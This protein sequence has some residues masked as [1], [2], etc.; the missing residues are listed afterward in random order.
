LKRAIFNVLF[1]ALFVLTSLSL[2]AKDNLAILPFTGGQGDEGETIAELFSFN[3][4]LKDVFIPIPRT[5]ITQAVEREQLFQMDSGMTNFKTIV[6]IAQQLGAR[7]V[8]AGHITSI[9]NNKLLVISIIDI[10]NLQQVTGD[11]QT[12]TNMLDIR[13]KLP[14]MAANIIQA[15]QRN[16]ASLPKLAVVP[17]QLQGGV[18]QRVAD[19]LTQILSIHLIRS[20]KY[21][22]YPRTSSLEQVKEEYNMQ[23]AFAAERN[24]ISQGLGENPNL[25]LSVVARKLENVNMFN[26]VIIDLFTG[27]Q[28]IGRSVDYRDIDEGIRAMEK[29]TIELTSTAEEI[30]QQDAKAQKKAKWDEIVANATRNYMEVLSGYVQFGEDILGGG[31]SILISG[32]YFSPFKFTSLGIEPKLYFP[33][34]NFGHFPLHGSVT[35]G[36]VYPFSKQTKIFADFIVDMGDFA[37]AGLKGIFADWATPCFDAGLFHYIDEYMD[38]TIGVSIKYR[39]TWYEGYYTHSIGIGFIWL[40][41]W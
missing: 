8:V 41:A 4:R 19:T 20:G 21:T 9:G 39:G 28:V 11:Y 16:T 24:K 6:A 2:F 34:T 35:M 18:D 29:L 32:I 40:A 26:A 3:D 14:N 12:Y 5:S 36:L 15:T 1:I 10:R 30:A 38:F 33:S 13:N 31:G 23:S 27:G 17:V 22:V 37:G 25:V 7:Y